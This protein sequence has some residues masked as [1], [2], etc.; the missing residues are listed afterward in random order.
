M[1]R[2]SEQVFEFGPYR[3]DGLKRLLL[4]DDELVPLTPKVFDTLLVLIEHDGEIVA[5]DTLMSTV[6]PDTVVEE[7]GLSRNISVLRKKL[8]EGP[9]DHRYIVT[10]PGRGYRFVAD[11]TRIGPNGSEPAATANTATN[12]IGNGRIRPIDSE[13]VN[14][15]RENVGNESAAPPI[16][17]RANIAISFPDLYESPETAAEPEFI[18]AAIDGRGRH[19]FSKYFAFG[20]MAVF[21][22]VSYYFLN[23]TPARI[24]TDGSRIAVLPLKPIDTENRD[25]IFEFAIAESLILKL[26]SDKNLNV[27]PLS[28]VRRYIE[29]DKDPIDAG[30]EL[31]VDFVLSSNYQLVNGRI[32]VTSQLLNVSTGQT[33]KTITSESN[34]SDAFS[35]QDAVAN[36][37]GN[38][39]F[40]RFGK[41]GTAYAAKRGTENEEAY[42]LYLQGEYLVEKKNWRD[43]KRAIEI[44]DAALELDPNY[45]RAW[46]GKAAAHCT[47]AHVGGVEPK[48]GFTYAK[49]AIARAFELDPNLAEGHAV[50]GIISFDYDWDFDKGLEHFRKAFEIDPKHEMARRW[51]AMRLAL[52]GRYDE[53]LAEI[54]TVIDVNPNSIFHQWEFACIL[55]QSRRYDEAIAQLHRVLEMDPDMA[56]ASRLIWVS[57]HMKGDQEQAYTWFMRFQEK[58]KADPAD[59]ESFRQ[60]HAA[61]GWNGVLVKN[62]EILKARYK[63]DRYDPAAAYNLLISSLVGDKEAAF[64][65]AGDGVK[66]RDLWV[67]ILLNDPA[68]DSLRDDPRFDLLLRRADLLT[69]D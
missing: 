57:Y 60:T 43:A 68:F 5:K 35:M 52:L 63:N 18:P 33:E 24:E 32:R 62:S 66:Y 39:V 15:T 65:F 28:A 2:R 55:Y 53:A 25:P 48:L 34:A 56:W 4:R 38:A 42:R 69:A 37:I 21:A 50:L 1:E 6:W 58:R 27:R 3:L 54:K 47:F 10:V 36:D 64:K 13:K 51:Y 12:I 19:N 26:S 45:A 8:G 29:L 59:I 30:R 11:V 20:L 22:A 40:A 49:P 41:T 23:S 44:F 61:S 7:G 14:A 16:R 9:T 17:Q 31:K 46:A 67:P